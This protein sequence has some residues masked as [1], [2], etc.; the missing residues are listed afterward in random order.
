MQIAFIAILAFNLPQFVPVT[1]FG[2]KTGYHHDHKV[3]R[4]TFT[5][6]LEQQGVHVSCKETGHEFVAKFPRALKFCLITWLENSRKQTI[7]R[8]MGLDTKGVFCYFATTVTQKR[9]SRKLL[10]S[11]TKVTFSDNLAYDPRFKD[12][13]WRVDGEI[14]GFGSSDQSNPVMVTSTGRIL[15]VR[16]PQPMLTKTGTLPSPV[17]KRLIVTAKGKSFEIYDYRAPL[18]PICVLDEFFRPTFPTKK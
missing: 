6:K 12:S 2:A 17:P 11:S 15:A 9:S 10:P 7:Y 14:I 13:E 4:V 3:D 5:C 16:G 18:R 1:K 8:G